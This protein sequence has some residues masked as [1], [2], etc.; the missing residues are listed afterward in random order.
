[1]AG[2]FVPGELLTSFGDGDRFCGR[3]V[4]ASALSRQ[5]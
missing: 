1:M 3:F 2:A 5:W 4:L